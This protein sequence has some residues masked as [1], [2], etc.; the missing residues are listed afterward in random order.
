MPLPQ[1][2]PLSAFQVRTELGIASNLSISMLSDAVR[3]L[4]GQPTGDVKFSELL[5]KTN[6]NTKQTFSYTGDIQY[7]TVPS[8]VYSVRVKCWGAGGGCGFVN[9]AGGRGGYSQAEFSV[10]PGQS[11]T[12]VVGGGGRSGSIGNTALYGGGGNGKGGGGSGGG[13]CSVILPSSWGIYAGG[14]GGTGDANTGYGGKPA[15]NGG[16]ANQSGGN[17]ESYIFQEG[18]PGNGGI[19]G[20]TSAGGS[21]GWNDTLA[22]EGSVIDGS[23]LTGGDGASYVASSGGG[24]AGYYGGGG[25]GAPSGSGAGGSG[26]ILNGTNVLG[27]GGGVGGSVPYY[28]DVDYPGGPIAE[29]ANG[30]GGPG[31][32]AFAVIRY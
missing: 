28:L 13:L 22:K 2:F 31:G 24:G 14:G 11:L 1:S 16:G 21:G 26:Y 32:N 27:G 23:F 4:A 19:G 10:T 30:Y 3:T 17:A 15:G 20:T 25:G 6:Y 5:G 8:G 9:V 7:W 18:Y 12:L 29:G